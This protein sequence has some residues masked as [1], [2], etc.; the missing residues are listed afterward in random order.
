[1]ASFSRLQ[2]AAALIEYD[3]DPSNPDAPFRSA[4]DS[5]I[6]AH[7]RS[8]PPLPARKSPDFLGV[9]IPSSNGSGGGRDST[10]GHVKGR[11]SI[12]A[13][14]NPFGADA[15]GEEDD[16]L[17]EAPEDD[18]E[19]DLASWGLDSFIPKEKGSKNTKK[20]EK[21]TTLPNPHP[22]LQANSYRSARSMSLGNMESFG[23]GG[24]FLDSGSSTPPDVR[25]R[26][27]GSALDLPDDRQRPP[28]RQQAASVH[29]LIDSLP[30]TAPLHSVPFPSQSIRSVSPAPADDGGLR[31]SSQMRDRRYSTAS[32]GS[33]LLNEPED[34]PF[35]LK[36]P[37]PS[38][39]SRFDPKVRARTMSVGTMG[40]MGQ[41]NAF[42]VRPP[43][44]SRSS[45]FDPKAVGHQRTHSNAS[46]GSRMLLDNDDASMFLG[47]APQRRERPY[48]TLELMRPKVLVMPSP[49]QGAAPAAPAP[50][51]G[52]RDGFEVSTDGPPLPPASRARRASSQTL[53]TGVNPPASAVPIASN[54]FTPNPRASMTL[55]QLTFRNS[56]MV[57]GQRDV[58]YN[59]LDGQLR[60][61]TE[62]GEQV[63]DDTPE[64]EEP[65][66]PVTVVVEEA[67]TPGRP[68]G[69]LYGRSLVDELE[70]RKATM[71]GKQ[72]VFTGDD[73]PSMMARNPLQRSSTLIDPAELSPR[74][75]S[76][77]GPPNARPPLSR[78]T[79]SGTKPLLTFNDSPTSANQLS[80][81]LSSGPSPGLS[82]PGRNG[83]ATRSVFGVDTLWEREVAKLRDIEAREAEEHQKEEA[84]AAAKLEKKMAKKRKGKEKA[85]PQETEP[86]IAYPRASEEP[87]VLPAIPKGVTRGPPPVIN[88]SDSDSDS[89]DVGT[90]A[91]GAARK[92]T[93]TG[94]ERW[95]AGSS[96][97][98]HEGPV[99]TTG[100]G[101]RYPN[102]A[103]G[104][105]LSAPAADDDSE[106]D[107]PLAATVGRAIQRATRLGAA[108]ADSDSD[109]DEPLS[110]LLEKSKLGIPSV[111]FDN[112]L[113]PSRS[114]SQDQG[115][116]RAPGEDDEDEDNQPLA[117][118]ASR[119][120]PMQ[121]QSGK[122]G[123][124]DE[125]EDDRPLAFH[126]EQQRRT[127]Y[128][129]MLQQ[130]QQQ[131][132]QMM[133]QAQMQS[134]MMFS[135]PSLMGSGFFGPPMAPPMLMAMP[136]PVPA[137][138]PPGAQDPTKFV[139][140]DRWR[141]D[142]A[143]EGPPP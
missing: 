69:K 84:A 129:M 140:V 114:A 143:V 10:M 9:A 59:D 72:R 74:P 43:S 79:S 61:A 75:V 135:N 11:G 33:R 35:A 64:E 126:P 142:V 119:F 100:V 96:D 6:F 53:L 39:A 81:G 18:M 139:R 2:L 115:A 25:R 138:P 7:L 42:A 51:V 29:A 109:S 88:D 113:S 82:P 91:P 136:P 106:E 66:R 70:L 48:S 112:T 68:V 77:V 21:M 95:F 27:L 71:R 28:L 46:M 62:E 121:S 107:L 78:R 104:R 37:S 80:P 128:Q 36:P 102:R 137:S 41:D 50:P 118:R 14:R 105:S 20:K 3:N 101:P 57:G 73:R 31:S 110:T 122:G 120:L 94:A 4:H 16:L 86:V 103:R 97:D 93:E 56:L 116:R 40:S 1:M 127:Q 131:Q 141:R 47:V 24:A 85:I 58:A 54:S 67:D 125:D 63:V 98:G 45:R 108:P 26:S 65:V 99:R 134:S 12:D 30:V 15:A 17:E 44:P 60:R 87:P 124:G 117:L 13:L 92:S 52:V 49:L 8:M 83:A 132:Q 22:A 76:Q 90:P 34:N 89:T 133:F 38:Q 111:D 23:A 32:M 5:A 19:V 130:Q 123:D 55:S